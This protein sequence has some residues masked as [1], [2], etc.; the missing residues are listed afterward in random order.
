MWAQVAGGLITSSGKVISAQGR[1]L[2][3][4][5]DKVMHRPKPPPP[6]RQLSRALSK[7]RLE[8]KREKKAKAEAKAAVKGGGVG[9]PARVGPHGS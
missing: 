6:K 2:T 3:T 7:T 9:P 4:M 1:L 8:E 5:A